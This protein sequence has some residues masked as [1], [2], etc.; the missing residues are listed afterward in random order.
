[1]DKN[2]SDLTGEKA[3]LK[4]EVAK[5]KKS[6]QF[7]T[8]QWEENFKTLDKLRNELSQNQKHHQQQQQQPV[9]L[10]LKAIKAERF[11]KA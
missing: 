10:D 2:I 6:L 3:V 1:M 4:N 5:L 8:D 11:K 9:T 7:H